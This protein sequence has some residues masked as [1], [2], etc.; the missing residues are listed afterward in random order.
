MVSVAGL[1]AHVAS[2]TATDTQ[3]SAGWLDIDSAPRDR[4]RATIAKAAALLSQQADG[5]ER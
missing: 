4:A 1:P 5:G 2:A 3:H